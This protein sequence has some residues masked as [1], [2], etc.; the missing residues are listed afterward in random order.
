VIREAVWAAGL[1]DARLH[2]LVFT[3]RDGKVH[4]I[5]LREANLR[6]VK[7]YEAQSE[8]NAARRR[9]SRMDG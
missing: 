3:P 2:V 4:V 9:E 8:R 7:R 1:I 5:S 6:E